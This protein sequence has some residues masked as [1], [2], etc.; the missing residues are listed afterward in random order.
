MNELKDTASEIL[1]YRT[2]DGETKLEVRLEEENVWLTQQQLAML[3]HTTKQNV[4]H[5]P[6]FTSEGRCAS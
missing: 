4:A 1:I 2:E 6:P 3:L 5:L